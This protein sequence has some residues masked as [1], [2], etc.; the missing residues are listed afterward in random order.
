MAVILEL[1]DTIRDIM[2]DAIDTEIGTTGH[3]RI[4]DGTMPATTSDANAG[5]LL[6]S[7]NLPNPAFG[8]SAAG[9]MAKN[10]TWQDTSADG[11]GTAQYFRI[12]DNTSGTPTTDGCVIQGNVSTA[13]A[14]LNLDNTS[15]NTGQ[16]VTIS[17]FT[18]T[19]GNDQDTQ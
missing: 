4:Y 5:T 8:A 7:F 14:A 15:I 1:S 13:S 17:T 11:T 12:Y 19:A 6:V 2:M 9:V 10:G 18:L 16:Q 3:F